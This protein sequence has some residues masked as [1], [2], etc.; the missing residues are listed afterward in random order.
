MNPEFSIAR[1]NTFLFICLLWL[2]ICKINATSVSNMPTLKPAKS[3]YVAK[4]VL[5][6]SCTDGYVLN[7]SS[8]LTCLPNGSWDSKV[9]PTCQGNFYFTALVLYRK[10]FFVSLMKRGN[11]SDIT[12]CKSQKSPIVC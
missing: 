8:T 11:F 10:N 6:L 7:G 1:T 2:A 4:D 3:Y 9:F 12:H 5:N